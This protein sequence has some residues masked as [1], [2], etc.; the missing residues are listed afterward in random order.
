MME[1]PERHATS[2]IGSNVPALRVKK[3]M[4]MHLR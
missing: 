3:A 1:Q 2:M 4:K